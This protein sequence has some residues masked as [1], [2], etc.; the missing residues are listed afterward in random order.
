MLEVASAKV[1][2][3]LEA[4]DPDVER[5]TK[6]RQNLAS[7]LEVCRRARN[8]LE[9]RQTAPRTLPENLAD[10][11]R[12]QQSAR[13]GRRHQPRLP[14]G[15]RYEMASPEEFARFD[16]LGPITADE[17]GACDVDDLARRLSE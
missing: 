12:R 3:S 11:I 16:S 8:A 7:T 9:R 5:L 14:L 1:Q 6:I 13:R 2:K 10:L 4:P 17:V 15:A